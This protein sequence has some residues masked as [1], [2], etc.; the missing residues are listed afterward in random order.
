MAKEKQQN[1]EH[2]QKQSFLERSEF[3]NE[4]LVVV[5]KIT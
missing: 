3:Y 4:I 1:K 5:S 2:F